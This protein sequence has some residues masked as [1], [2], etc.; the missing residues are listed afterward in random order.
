MKQFAAIIL[1]AIILNS[2]GFSQTILPI[3]HPFNPDS[4]GDEFVAVSDVLMSIASYDTDYSVEPMMVDSITFEEAMQRV[5]QKLDSL[6]STTGTS[7]VI[8]DTNDG[9]DVDGNSVTTDSTW[10]CGDPVNYWG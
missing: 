7:V 2:F 9:S 1:S 5:L 10:A 8:E 4:D 3:E 6:L